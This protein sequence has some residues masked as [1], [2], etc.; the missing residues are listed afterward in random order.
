MR[1]PWQELVGPLKLVD[2]FVK[3]VLAKIS[4]M[5]LARRQCRA[6]PG[7]DESPGALTAPV[8]PRYLSAADRRVAAGARRAEQQARA[9][10]T[11]Q[12]RNAA[13]GTTAITDDERHTDDNAADQ[14]SQDDLT[15][16]YA[17]AMGA[18]QHLTSARFVD[19]LA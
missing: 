19:L 16:P 3:L 2:R 5:S 13:Q 7:N 14:I 8:G 15:N 10:L 17:A 12:K 18:I 1:M 6:L 4:H 9:E 11:A